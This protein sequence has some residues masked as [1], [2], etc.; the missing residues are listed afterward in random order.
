MRRALITFFALSLWTACG[1]GETPT[2]DTGPDE[3]A[4]MDMGGDT[5]EPDGGGDTGTPDVASDAGPT[6]QLCTPCTDNAECGGED[7]LCVTLFDEEQA[8]GRACS[9]DAPCPEGYFCATV[10]DTDAS[11]CVP[12][13]L[14]CV[15]RC[16]DVDCDDG[17]I[18]DPLTGECRRPLRLCETD[19]LISSTCGDGPEDICLN[20]PDTPDGERM[21]AHGCDPEAETPECPADF[22]CAALDPDNDPNRGVCFPFMGTC[23]DRC[24]DVDCPDGQNCDPVTGQCSQALY[25]ACEQGCTNNTEC[26]GQDDVCL[27]LGIG[28]GPHCW[29]AC[30]DVT[31][32]A[33]GYDC[34]QLTGTTLRVCIPTGMDCSACYDNQCFP[35]ARCNP[36][37]DVCEPIPTSCTTD[38]DC[39]DGQ[40]CATGLQICV[41]VGR[42]CDGSTW[43]VDC[44]NDA[45]K[46]TTQRPGTTGRC[47]PICVTDADCEDPASCIAANVGSLCLG[48]D[49]GGAETCGTLQES[50][51]AVGRPCTSNSNCFGG[52]NLCIREGNV[53]GFC[54]RTC[55]SDGDC[56]AGQRC[57][58]AGGQMVCLPANCGCAG[59]PD[60]GAT[61]SDALDVAWL[62]ANRS[63]CDVVFEP[64]R[65]TGVDQVS[66]LAFSSGTTE[67]RV[68]YPSASIGEA[69]QDVGDLDDR[70]DGPV[71]AI[72]A[73]ATWIDADA[74]PPSPTYSYPG[75]ESQVAQAVAA[76]ITTAGGTPDLGA[77]DTAA[78]PIPA[79]IEETVA[80]LVSAVD[81]T[82]GVR[83]SAFTTY[84]WQAGDQAALFEGSPYLVLPGTD[85]QTMAAPD[86]TDPAT[87]QTMESFDPTLM[88][89]ASL[90]LGAEVETAIAELGAAGA[91]PD[92]GVV[93]FDTPAGKVIVGDA[94]AQTY[95]VA[96][97]G[98]EI[99][100]L[101]DLGGDDTY[102]IPAGANA[103]PENG[104]ALVLDLEGTDDYGYDEV[105]D[106]NDD[107]ATL[108]SDADGRVTPTLP[109]NQANGPISAS[110]TA[111][112]GA[113]RL[114]VGM[115]VDVGSGTD[116]YRSLRMSQG[117]AVFGV[118]LLYDDGTATFEAEAL[119]QGAAIGGVGVLW[120]AGSNANQ[121]RVWH[122]GQGFGSAGGIGLAFDRGSDDIW[123]AEPGDTGSV[124]YLS[125][126]DRGVSNRNL[127]QGAAFGELGGFAGGSGVLRDVAGTDSYTA[128]TFAQG[129]GSGVAFALL[130]DGS[131]DDTYDGRG[132][133][134]GVG[135]W[136]A[137]GILRDA[138]GDD[139]YNL[140]TALRLLGEGVGQTLGWGAFVDLDGSDD[141]QYHPSGGGVGIDGG[142]G[143]FLSG[144]GVDT[145]TTGSTAS[146]GF[147]QIS[148]AMGEVGYGE[149]TTGIFVDA[150]G[151]ADTYVRG[152]LG[153]V[154]NDATWLQPAMPDLAV[155][156]G[157]DQ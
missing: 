142:F 141:V 146:W 54:S 103:S 33:G 60:V 46:C 122:A 81:A 53:D 71:D 50:T 130:A 140:N 117:A 113:G 80:D 43:A 21:C 152:S 14:T 87:R 30:S 22:F 92:F 102:R 108:A 133:V 16:S 55:T 74:V 154:A 28:D 23:V 90:L 151:D 6:D 45:T 91:Q 94:T 98:D 73:A 111:R 26:G 61:A 125:A 35:D 9:E 148:A 131:G 69:S 97:Y 58:L 39:D 24:A 62:Q 157:V 120:A 77:L 66:D 85:A 18:C 76:L 34:A 143:L 27:N 59:S 132:V 155:G 10:N 147:A 70:S 139:E 38:G 68:R 127:A 96:T 99:A 83:Q 138:S 78:Q 29:E 2:P 93:E 137:A 116:S 5:G 153:D 15:D 118:G 12:E 40:L 105:A 11:Q 64:R 63:Q 84:G 150:G 126:V 106:P 42:P 49:L 135:E 112:Q 107:S 119:A 31:D 95:D 67:E 104:V 115:L 17:D 20:V 72:R 144:A 37:D 101:I 86:L 41:D 57:G 51:T 47:E 134:Q 75:G 145:H 1:P 110:D 65:F 114:G 156:V 25:G 3:D 82:Y 123:L 88:V 44:D 52:A 79:A 100:L 109:L 124:L 4:G 89:E 19:C 48:D 8:C 32:C 36:V 136:R 128:G 149:P 7:D 56:D 13:I 121:Y 129:Y